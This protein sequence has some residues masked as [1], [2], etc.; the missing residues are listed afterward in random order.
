VKKFAVAFLSLAFIAST[1][2]P[3]AACAKAK[4]VRR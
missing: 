2:T 4:V 1:V 3:A